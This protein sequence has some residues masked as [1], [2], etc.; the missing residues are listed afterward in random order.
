MHSSIPPLHDFLNSTVG[1]KE[2]ARKYANSKTCNNAQR[3]V[4]RRERQ[5]RLTKVQGA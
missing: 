1:Y 4:Y 2:D 3:T 5:T